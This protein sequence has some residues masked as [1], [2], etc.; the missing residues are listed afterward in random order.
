MDSG[1]W[2]GVWREERERERPVQAD[3]VSDIDVN[4]NE[5]REE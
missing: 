2:G 1:G 5:S 3:R 4:G